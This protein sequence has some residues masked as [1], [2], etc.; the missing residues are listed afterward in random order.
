MSGDFEDLDLPEPPVATLGDAAHLDQAGIDALF[1]D[2]G[3]P[4]ETKQG[5]RAVIE[6]DV[7]GHERLP[8]LEVVF[9]RM[10]RIFAT[11]MRNLTSDAIDVSLESVNSVRFGDFLNHVALPAMIGVF[12]IEEW[13]NYGLVTV[14]SGLIY[15]V[16]DA[17]LGGRSDGH[18]EPMVIDGRAFTTIET[19]LVARMLRHVL[20]DMSSALGPIT[21]NTMALERIETSPRFASIAGSTNVCA[22][23]TFRVDMDER[24][25][26]FTILLPYATIE[27]VRHLLAQ[28][29]VGEKLGRD[30]IWQSH[31]AAE[32]RRTEVS[33]DVVLGERMIPLSQVRK[34]AVGQTIPLHQD[35]D[36]PLELQCGGI[37]L[38]KGQIGQRSNNIAVRLV[39]AINE[40][41]SL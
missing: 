24:G 8:M 22:V 37:T 2:F 4:L 16:V 7:I 30:G 32:L 40:G 38:G 27:P 3:S 21:P 33:L 6:S 28:R 18:G 19:D 26:R 17:L 15:A 5:L 35:P 41:G 14:D 1:D 25:G 34:L 10:V 39:H 20:A 13:E 36:Q 11:S 12:R 23:A 29:F 9:D 31:L